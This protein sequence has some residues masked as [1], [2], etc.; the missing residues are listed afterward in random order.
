MYLT[1]RDIIEVIETK[2]QEN[3]NKK[4]A[5]WLQNY[6]K[7]SVKSLG[8]GIPKIRSIMKRLY[9]EQRLN[10]FAL[11]KQKKIIDGLM[12]RDYSEYKLAAILYMQL[13]LKNED[14]KFQ[15]STIFSWFE[16]K[17]IYDWNVCDWLCV[18]CLSPLV[19]THPRQTI[20]EL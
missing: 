1:E 15:L 16:N 17:Y 7:R 14:A 12:K 10:E 5:E 8:V 13:N 2:L 20:A 11:N 19:D 18:R 4:K 3:Y 6:V 9:N